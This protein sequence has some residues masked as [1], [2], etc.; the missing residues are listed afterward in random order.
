MEVYSMCECERFRKAIDIETKRIALTNKTT[1]E[2]EGVNALLVLDLEIGDHLFVMIAET[3]S[4]LD[5]PDLQRIYNHLGGPLIRGVE[6]LLEVEQVSL[7]I[8]RETKRIASAKG[9]T[10]QGELFNALIDLDIE[11]ANHL[12]VVLS[13]CITSLNLSQLQL[14]YNYLNNH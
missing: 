3:M 13:D 6:N 12:S 5:L 14:L 7:G 2:G 10:C 8:E 1:C 9:T 4:A 11:G